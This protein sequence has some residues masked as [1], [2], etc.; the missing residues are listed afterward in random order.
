MC[1][2]SG[3]GQRTDNGQKSYKQ[4]DQA[5]ADIQKY[6]VGVKARKSRTV[7]TS[8]RAVCVQHFR[9][10]MRPSVVQ[11][12]HHRRHQSRNAASHQNSNRRSQTNQHRPLHLKWLNLFSKKLW[13]PAHHQSGNKHC[14]D[15]KC[16]HSI[17]TAAS[18]AEDHLAKLH[19]QHGDHSAKRCIAV[20][21]GVDGA[22]GGCCGK[23]RPGRGS[24]NA[25]AGLFSL[26][27]SSGLIDHGHID[28]AVLCKLR[29]TCLFADCD[30]SKGNAQA[31]KHRRKYGH[32]LL[33]VLYR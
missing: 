13:C 5:N 14:Q 23:C 21:H 22:V 7:V 29:C 27:I 12:V 18:A 24:R 31:N 9:E 17:Q 20:V 1:Q 11:T 4:H 8:G 32:T 6:G 33:F 15:G 25:E 3:N 30:T 26:H 16:Q 2:T 19:Q 28:C 10:T